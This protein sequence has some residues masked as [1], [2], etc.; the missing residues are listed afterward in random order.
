MSP[1]PSPPL[2]YHPAPQRPKLALPAGA[3]DAHVHVHVL[4]NNVGG[5]RAGERKA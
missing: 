3:C 2:S 1:T 5:R 4:V